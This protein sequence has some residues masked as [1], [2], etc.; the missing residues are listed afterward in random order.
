MPGSL[1][2][3]WLD[4]LLWGTSSGGSAG[5]GETANTLGTDRQDV[6]VPVDSYHIGGLQI[7]RFGQLL[8]SMS[9]HFKG[10]TRLRVLA[11]SSNPFGTGE[12]GF[13]TDNSNNAKF[14]AANGAITTL[15]AG[16]S[17]DGLLGA[18]QAASS[19]AKNII[20]LTT[21]L[22]PVLIR[23][24]STPI[25]GTL[26]G[27][28]DNAGTT[29]YLD[30]TS[31]ST[32]AIKSGMA[33]GASAVACAVDTSTAWSNATAKLFS[34][35]N[36][37]T[38]KAFIDQAGNQEILGRLMIGGT[39]ASFPGVATGTDDFGQTGVL[40]AQKADNSARGRFEAGNINST[41]NLSTSSGGSAIFFAST[42]SGIV[43]LASGQA[44]QWDTGG[45]AA[46]NTPDIVLSR[47]AA[48]TLANNAKYSLTTY[49]TSP[50]TAVNAARMLSVSSFTPS[51]SSPGWAEMHL[52]P[53]INGTS[54]GTATS[55]AIASK[56]NTLTG[57]KI[58]LAD[59]GTSSTDYFTGFTRKWAVDINGRMYVVNTATATTDW[60]ASSGWGTSNSVS[61][62]TGDDTH[63]TVTVTSGS[64]SFTANPTLT[65]TFKNGTFGTAPLGAISKIIATSDSAT[66]LT[67]AVTETTTATTLVITFNGTAVASKT[68][69]FRYV[70]I[71]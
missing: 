17:I 18:Y 36:N 70:V 66:Q 10:G 61:A 5:S 14:T 19:T 15:A 2:S 64:A 38:E 47:S 65:L 49:T 45:N 46:A 30:L 58:F 48:A 16:A 9:Q 59:W 28:Q 23:D 52:N 67:I 33:D 51:A 20:G 6:R 50:S 26:F 44:L 37:G 71:G 41:G 34:V 57:G 43:A 13:W 56:T 68:Y 8:M 3:N 55:L 42:T 27:L 62:V 63:G 53:T 54:T 40:V 11:Q 60:A 29:K 21:A 35:K 39:T 22:G 4:T 7:A 31:N 1:P 12:A 32:Q 25:S 24:N 69:Q